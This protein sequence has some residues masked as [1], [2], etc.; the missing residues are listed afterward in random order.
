MKK[1]LILSTLSLMAA[2]AQSPDAIAPV[3][4]TGAFDG[5]S[6]ASAQAA[7][8]NERQSLA[9]LDARQRGA[10]AGDAVGVLL[11]GVPVA[12]LTGS[13]KAGLIGASKG[14]ILALEQRVASC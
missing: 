5:L 3:S 10:V 6:C 2:C 13:D 7:L 12:S 11:I 9:A 14:K 4:M 1:I 8:N